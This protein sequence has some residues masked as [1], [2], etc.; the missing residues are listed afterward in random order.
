MTE[1]ARI[2]QPLPTGLI[3]LESPNGNINPGISATFRRLW[4]DSLS[5]VA[6]AG[7]PGRAYGRSRL[8][9]DRVERPTFIARREAAVRLVGYADALM[10]NLG[11]RGVSPPPRGLPVEGRI[12]PRPPDADT[13]RART[14]N[15]VPIDITV[16]L[17]RPAGGWPDTITLVVVREPN[18][19]IIPLHIERESPTR[20]MPLRG[21]D[22]RPGR[23]Q[24]LFDHAEPSRMQTLGPDRYAA[25]SLIRSRVFPG[26]RVDVTF[27]ELARSIGDWLHSYNN[28]W[29]VPLVQGPNS[30]ART[31]NMMVHVAA[32]A[33]DSPSAAELL[34]ADELRETLDLRPLSM[35]EAAALASP[36]PWRLPPPRP[37]R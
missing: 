7:S 23:Q 17:E 18:P 26:A 31:T 29:P 11:T 3:R 27:L 13:P 9:A 14:P 32:A 1:L 4:A 19:N 6:V 35:A 24:T 33:L 8:Y 5:R 36:G 20:D 30:L 10:A 34:A 16:H 22:E 21:T 37:R 12:G 2:V 28:G 25:L 15:R